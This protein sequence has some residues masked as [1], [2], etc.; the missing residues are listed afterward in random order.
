MT[1]RVITL[2]GSTAGAYYVEA[3][4]NYYLDAGEPRG[5]WLGIGA[6]RLGLHGD[7]ADHEFLAVM[8]GE[9]PRRPGTPLGRRFGET[10]VRGFDVTCSAPKSVSVLFALADRET[11]REVTEAHD[12][13]VTVVAGWIERTALTRLRIDG[14]IAV[15][16]AEGIIAAA[17]R[18]HT[19]RAL[20]PQLHTHL[21]VNNRVIAPDDRWLALDARGLKLD[22][23][24]A[25][26]IYHAALHTELTRR[27]GVEWVTADHSFAEVDC[28]PPD[29]LAA[30]STRTD[31]I[32]R[33]TDLKIDRFE[34]TMGRPP[35]PQERWRLEREAVVDSRPS[36]PQAVSSA[37]LH[38]EWNARAEAL[39]VRP[40]RLLRDTLGQTEGG[41]LDREVARSVIDDAVAHLEATQSTWRP[42]E[43]TREIARN[44]PTNLT[45]SPTELLDLLDALT[46][47]AIAG[48]CIE[49]SAP[50]LDGTPTRRDGRPVTESV[51]E[52]SLTTEAILRQEAELLNWAQHR[53]DA[54]PAPPARIA[55]DALSGLSGPQVQTATAIAGTD[56]LVLVVGPAGTGKTTALAPA[57]RHLHTQGR[58]VF[59]LAPSAAA[60]QVLT[61]ET[62]VVADTIDKLLVEHDGLRPPGKLY[63]LPAG[64]T[65]L[66]DEAGMVSTD[67]LA[68]LASLA[69]RHRWRVALIG[70]PLQFSAVGRGGMFDVLVDTHGAI[71]LDRVHR[72]HHAWERAASLRLRNGDVG[73][74][75]LYDHHGRIHGGTS[76][77]MEADALTAWRDA[78]ARGETVL[79]IAPTNEAVSRLNTMAQQIRIDTGEL[80]PNGRSVR[81][82]EHRIH[83]GE[84]IVTRRN[85]RALTTD[86]G[87]IVRNRD[88]W[89]VERVGADGSL[90]VAGPSGHIRL[91]ADYVTE[92]VQL[93]YAQ[94]SHAAQGRTVDRSILI[95]DG[96]TDLPG[97]YVPLTR[98][99]MSNDVYVAVTGNDTA[100][101]VIATSMARH[102]IDRPAHTH[103]PTQPDHV[104]TGPERLLSGPELKELFGE[105]VAIRIEILRLDQRNRELAA[106][107][108]GER[109][110]LKRI[111]QQISYRESSI[112]DLT[113]RLDSLRGPVARLANRA[114]IAAT[115]SNL[116]RHHDAL[117]G[118]RSD[119]DRSRNRIDRLHTDTC[120]HHVRLDTRPALE[121]R[122][123]VIS[124]RLDRDA[125]KR[126]RHL[127]S[128][129]PLL[130][131]ERPRGHEAAAAW[132]RLAGRVDQHYAAFGE[133]LSP[134]A[135]WAYDPPDVADS[136]RAV[137]HAFRSL[138]STGEVDH[139]PPRGIERGLRTGR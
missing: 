122:R 2:K 15:V 86:H 65:L 103:V 84:D 98:G 125:D 130:Q 69:D 58:A 91:P 114:D 60:A 7:V 82:G 100:R 13:A 32:R 115:R 26:A 93:A 1:A 109:L 49:L 128:G 17:F 124:E 79:L 95:L 108:R 11:R 111:D 75:D 23:R 29:L 101:D 138:R 72:F 35:T 48:R 18:Q 51:I 117:H 44:L 16:D 107:L 24:T 70:D 118:L 22:Q 28:L 62:A 88:T 61:N 112:N 25:S 129:T 55:D 102:W 74:I 119:R 104:L 99:R 134:R 54:E 71:E 132:D 43:L 113:T 37:Q 57:V 110:N 78:H 38:R 139:G 14:Q 105:R 10:S 52:R 77:R 19:S 94:T 34:E 64:T 73:V 42:A 68:A 127:A 137:E 126:A 41:P 39:D 90:A 131:T 33:R 21:V 106:N 12:A 92:H 135:S 123:D 121:D 6:A 59:G 4:P 83:C 53:M 3:L 66:V 56:P 45:A 46:T 67:K 76:T 9:D 47:T 80:E 31:A 89:T 20:D 27:L 5:R 136:T 96:P 50:V 85:E 36:K 63:T 97:I 116:T 30:F 120:A 133:G 40:P 87:S 8:A 81:V